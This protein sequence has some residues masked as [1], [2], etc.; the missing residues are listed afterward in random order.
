MDRA[1]AVNTVGEQWSK[2]SRPQK[3]QWIPSERCELSCGFA[4]SGCRKT[5]MAGGAC[6]A[7]EASAGTHVLRPATAETDGFLLSWNLSPRFFL[8]ETGK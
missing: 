6:R 2:A 5:A 1:E 7:Q 3:G 8:G 4:Q